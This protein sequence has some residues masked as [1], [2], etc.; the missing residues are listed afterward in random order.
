VLTLRR[1]LG[2]S[3]PVLVVLS[4]ALLLHAQEADSDRA[5]ALLKQGVA[6]F[7]AMDFTAAKASLLKVDRERLSDQEKA[8]LE[9]H[10]TTVDSAI[11]KQ[12]EAM[13]SYNAAAKA[14]KAGDLARAKQGYAAVANSEYLPEAMRRDVQAQLALVEKKLQTSSAPASRP[15]LM[16]VKEPPPEVKAEKPR[17]ESPATLPVLKTAAEQVAELRPEP[18]TRPSALTAKLAGPMGKPSQPMPVSAQPSPVLAVA[19]TAAGPSPTPGEKPALP[20]AEKTAEPQ[21]LPTT[22]PTEVLALGTQ[23]QAEEVIES[24]TTKPAEV[25]AVEPEVEPK[26]EPLP[27]T[28]PA[29]MPAKIVVAAHKEQPTTKPA[30]IAVAPASATP[31]TAPADT[32]AV[33]V[34]SD[35]LARRSQANRLVSDGKTAMA[36][37]QLEVAVK[38][39]QQ[40]LALVPEMEDAKR[41]LKT[42]QDQLAATGGAAGPLSV[43]EQ[44]R[45]VKKQ[46]SDVEFDKGLARSAETLLG[47]KSAADFDNAADAARVAQNVVQGNKNLYSV[48]EYRDKMLEVENRLEGI[49][50]RRQ[51]WE[52]AQVQ[53]QLAQMSKA[54]AERARRTSDQLNKKVTSLTENAK[55][56]RSERKYK[57]AL[58]VV[59]QVQSLDPSN[60]WAADQ[61][62]MLQQFIL[63]QDQKDTVDTRHEQQTLSMRDTMESRIPWYEHL[64]FPR[65]WREIRQDREGKGLTVGYESEEDRRIHVAL[66]ETIESNMDFEDVPLVDVLDHVRAMTGLNIHPNWKFLESQGYT[67][68]NVVVSS[69]HLV[70]VSYEKALQVILEDASGLNVGTPQELSYVVDGGVI[71][72]TTKYDLSLRV[73]TVVYPIQDLVRALALAHRDFQ[74][75]G[76]INAAGGTTGGTGTSGTSGTTGTGTSSGSRSSGSSSGISTSSGGT[77]GGTGTSVGTGTS[78]GTGTTSEEAQVAV[79]N[80]IAMIT[81]TIS[82]E[83]WVG[84]GGE[85]HIDVYNDQLIVTQTAANHQAIANLITQLREAKEIQIAIEARFIT[86]NTGYL[87]SIGVDLDFYFNLGSPLGSGRRIDPWTG[88]TVPTP[89]GSSGWGT[90][91]PGNDKFTPIGAQ[92]NT[93][94][95]NVLGVS[96]PMGQNSIGSLVTSPA[97]NV[98]GTFLDDIQVDFLIRATQ[99]HQS[100]RTLTAPRLTLLNGTAARIHVGRDLNYVSNVDVTPGTIV[101]STITQPTVSYDT[102]TLTLGTELFISATVS[103]DLKYVTITVEPSVSRLRSLDFFPY[104]PRPLIAQGKFP[105]TTAF[106]QLPDTEV[107]TIQTTVNVP[108]GATLL[109]G[110]LKSVGEVER[111]IGVPLLS[112]I[113]IINRAFTNRG[114]VSD[115]ET[116]LILIKP[117]I[118][119]PRDQEKKEF[120]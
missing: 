88:A 67:K 8:V 91:P 50:Q 45:R 83:S 3:L 65:N 24:P 107:E 73:A 22:K 2:L 90:G 53:Q 41:L 78:T 28:P 70:K 86:V 72:I 113:P 23:G 52:K 26:L 68:E 32:E 10:L 101:G 111:E 105:E 31:S 44:K 62:E 94:F 110:G 51:D 27:P 118:I 102:S 81:N 39:F 29:T 97:M 37:N 18:A 34:F 76:D 11:R 6:Q 16:V 57:E 7:K 4:S 14:L 114:K 56:L 25:V 38:D 92:Q 40:A 109:L 66:K 108:D 15:A 71:A 98:Q 46:Q 64:I 87:E 5:S 77:A 12:S 54:Q 61:A 58:E 36:D 48:S 89:A 93:N 43:L 106:V 60:Y 117:N 104:D 17:M 82:P 84:M 103:A 119:I 42:A 116:L 99:A 80:L 85:G 69:V 20:E 95:G 33:K 120:P 21:P 115:E 19:E 13:A 47:A 112:K 96:S 1:I 63:L 79:D 55:A 75:F 49:Q 9:E 35:V 100:T 74:N 59:K 30:M